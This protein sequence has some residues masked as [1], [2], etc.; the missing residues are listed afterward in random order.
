MATRKPASKKRSTGATTKR[1]GT[2]KK[3]TTA[4]APPPRFEIPV[5][6]QRE[7]FAVVLVFLGLL[8]LLFSTIGGDQGVIG[9]NWNSAVARAFGTGKV[10][11]PVALGILGALIIYQERFSDARLT[12]AN[13][14]GT[15]MVLLSLLMLLEYPGHAVRQQFP[16]QHIGEG[17]GV[18]GGLMLAMLAKGI[19]RGGA[20]LLAITLGL[21]GIMLT[22]NLTIRQ[23]AHTM[24]FYSLGLRRLGNRLLG[25]PLPPPTLD[26]TREFDPL[27]LAPPTRPIPA[28]RRRQQHTA[29][30]DEQQTLED[31]VLT[32]IAERPAQ[33]SLFNRDPQSV[34]RPPRRKE[35]APPP[36]VP[37]QPI[38]SAPT[39]KLPPKA[40]AQGVPAAKPAA[41]EELEIEPDESNAHRAWPLPGLTMLDSYSEGQISD[42]E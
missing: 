20:L 35:P 31:L 22:F 42:E 3:R 36:V 7:I 34:Q 21:I 15:L 29:T 28:A 12:G 37:G 16:D 30:P 33:A 6:L 4:K 2:T 24:A 27:E 9:T 11:V 17:G 25:A 38:H 23:I 19:G 8:T 5:N 40:A 13:V 14:I 10:L 32:P 18:V 41:Q 26:A 1:T 39:T